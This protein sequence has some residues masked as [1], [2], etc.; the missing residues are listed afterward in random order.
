MKIIQL[1]SEL[2]QHETRAHDSEWIERK[3]NEQQR[4]IK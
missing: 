2:E 3:L 1:R 4:E